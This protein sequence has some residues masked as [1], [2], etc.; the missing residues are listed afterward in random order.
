MDKEI[1][2]KVSDLESKVT[3]YSKLAAK[4]LG[5]MFSIHGTQDCLFIRMGDFY[6]DLYYKIMIL[7][8]LI[9]K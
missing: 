5:H 8:E 9:D 7:N 6:E 4:M 1:K 3:Q 2:E